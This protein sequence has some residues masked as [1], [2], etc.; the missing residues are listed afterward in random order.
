MLLING[1]YFYSEPDD[2]WCITVYISD[3]DY[4]LKISLNE[5]LSKY[6]VRQIEEDE[7]KLMNIKK[8]SE[9][10]LF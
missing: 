5:I 2:F 10:K 3:L 4:D 9:E 6:G 1:K 8:N 7:Y